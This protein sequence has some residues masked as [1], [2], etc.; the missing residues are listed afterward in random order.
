MRVEV[1]QSI[2]IEQSGPTILA[3]AN[4]IS[5]AIIIP[6]SVK[7]AAFKLLRSTG[8]SSEITKWMIFA[9][10]IYLLLDTHWP[11]LTHITID[12]EYAGKNSDIKA[13]LLR[14]IWRKY[15]TFNEG[16]IQFG[17][18]GKGSPADTKARNV[19]LGRDR[20]FRKVNLKELIGVLT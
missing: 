20:G 5:G 15:P 16:V 10:G 1:D 3:F 8:K 2:K 14:Y 7:N 19:R 9:A 17:Y 18:V 11:K 12:V 13:S 6:S 4:G